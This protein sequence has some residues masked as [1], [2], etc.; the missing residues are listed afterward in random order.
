MRN[1]TDPDSIFLPQVQDYRKCFPEGVNVA[2]VES[3]PAINRV[4]LK[5]SLEN[6]VK[7]I[8]AISENGWTY[9]DLM[10]CNSLL[11]LRTVEGYFSY[12][13]L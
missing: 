10:V 7:D 12:L 11:Y 6:I 2:S 1:I 3:S 8:P 4:S 5:M 9:G 13:E